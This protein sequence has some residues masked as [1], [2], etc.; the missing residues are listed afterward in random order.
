M[1]S[2]LTQHF[3]SVFMEFINFIRNPIKKNIPTQEV[4]DIFKYIPRLLSYQA[5]YVKF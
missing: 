4:A 5:A 2:M 1:Q 3:L